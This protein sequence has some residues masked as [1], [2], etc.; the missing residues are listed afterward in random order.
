[1][2]AVQIPYLFIFTCICSAA[3][4]AKLCE[5]YEK[6][7]EGKDHEKRFNENNKIIKT[8]VLEKKFKRIGHI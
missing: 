3:F 5:G 6:K 7:I 8:K 1:M 2:L 4:D